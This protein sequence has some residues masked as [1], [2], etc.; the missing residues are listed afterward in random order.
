MAE[1]L[2]TWAGEG[3]SEAVAQVAVTGSW[4]SLDS[5][6]DGPEGSSSGSILDHMY[7]VFPDNAPRAAYEVR[8]RAD[9]SYRVAT[10]PDIDTLFPARLVFDPDFRYPGHP[11][12]GMPRPA[13]ADPTGLPTDPAVLAGVSALVEEFAQHHTRITGHAP[14]WE[15]GR[16]EEEIAEAESRIRARLP[17]DLRALFRLVGRD[18]A[19]SGLLGRYSHGSLE[20]LVEQ[21]WDGLPGASAEPEQDCPLDE[22]DVVLEA[23]PPGRVKRVSRNDWWVTFGDNGDGEAIVVDLDPGPAGRSGQVLEYGRNVDEPPRY[24]AGSVTEML[25]AVVNALR[26]D[27]YKFDEGDPRLRADVDFHRDRTPNRF[28][29]FPDVPE[30]DV[31]AAVAELDEPALIQSAG[32]SN[33]G[34]IDLGGLAPLVSLRR[35]AVHR[36]GS[37]R[38]AVSELAALESLSITASN[39]DLSALAGHPVLWDL[40]LAGVG[41]PVDLSVLATLPRLT[42]LSLAGLDVPEIERLGELRSLRMLTLDAAQLHQLLARDTRLPHL[43]ALSITGHVVLSDVVKFRRRLRDAPV[44]FAEFTGRLDSVVM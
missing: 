40:T 9:G 34:A 15:P 27:R 41:H 26:E 43:A 5:W 13:A 2:R 24:V 4:H 10:S 32:L 18:A 7:G 31:R 30:L 6:T 11:L 23:F 38:A 3:W 35:L 8:L 29:S 36:A 19:E 28:H 39:V 22:E 12:P 44:R 16:T 14:R 20:D 25:S 33:E 1:R 21:Y 17:E 42:R 37:V